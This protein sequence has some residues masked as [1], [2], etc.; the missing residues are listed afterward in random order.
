MWDH[1][2]G[3]DPRRG[4]AARIPHPLL[5]PNSIYLIS[6]P[7]EDP[8]LSERARWEQLAREGR[9]CEAQH[10]NDYEPHQEAE[11]FPGEVRDVI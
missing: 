3:P 6:R 5:Q 9:R 1:P 11:D 2:R 8:S 4:Q 10:A 7:F